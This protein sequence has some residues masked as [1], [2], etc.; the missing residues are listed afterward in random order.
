M[1]PSFAEIKDNLKAWLDD[2]LLH[3]MDEGQLLLVLGTFFR[4]C[5]EKGLKVSALA[6]KTKIFKQKVRW[7]GRIISGEGVQFDPE[8]VSGLK[9]AHPPTTAGELC[10][11]VHCL[12][13][14][15][16]AISDFS[17][18]VAPLRMVLEDAYKK[19]GKRTK[20]S[21]KNLKLSELSWGPEHVDIFHSFQEQLKKAITLSHRD[22]NKAI[23]VYTDASDLHWSAVVTQCDSMELEKD[24]SE[25]NHQH[26]A[27]LSSS[28][29]KSEL[30]WSTSR[31]R[32]SRFIR[33]SRNFVGM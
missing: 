20:R 30:N 31:K 21:I 32:L 25:Q 3:C 29:K 10:Q 27:F 13:W 18:R 17:G 14:M 1:K 16:Q 19:S 15:A 24:V 12:Q 8:R 33:L 4:I 5:R 9:D 6:H 2:F 11:D 26:L 23:C 7:C 22:T 28:F